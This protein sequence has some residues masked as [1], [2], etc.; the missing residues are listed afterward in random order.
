VQYSGTT[1]NLFSV[2][3][4]GGLFY[5]LGE[6]GIILTSPDGG[7]WSGVNSGTTASLNSIAYGAGQF[8]I[9]GTGVVLG[10]TNGVN[11]QDI[12]SKVPTVPNASSV[13]FLNQSFWIVG[14]NGSMLQSDS[15]DGIPR[16]NGTMLAGNSG[17]QL[18]IPLNVPSTYRIQVSTNLSANS[19]QDVVTNYAPTSV[20][21]DTNALG[22]SV[23]LYRIASP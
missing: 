10:S 13:A 5:A 20:W 21:T 6:G 4:F 7:A 2:R 15:A 23:R 9:C 22:S 11:W 8:V 1:L 12:S 19:W 14:S 16:L 3:Y 18:K 17:F